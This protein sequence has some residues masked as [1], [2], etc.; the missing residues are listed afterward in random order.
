MINK[1]GPWLDTNVVVPTGER[2][3]KVIY[4]Y[5]LEAET[6]KEKSLSFVEESLRESDVVQQEDTGLCEGVQKGVETPAY[7]AAAGRYAPSI[8]TPMFNFHRALWNA[9]K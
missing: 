7:E 6:L 9:I 4:D 8:E 3:C 1:Y 2:T 5:W